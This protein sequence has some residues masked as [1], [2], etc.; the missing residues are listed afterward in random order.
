MRALPILLSLTACGQTISL[1]IEVQTSEVVRE[2][3]G[4]GWSPSQC[5]PRH[6][7]H[8][9][10]QMALRWPRRSAPSP[11]IGPPPGAMVNARTPR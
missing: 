5:S 3:H 4:R 6:S 10:W 11:S 2:V 1:G 7:P 9:C 8:R